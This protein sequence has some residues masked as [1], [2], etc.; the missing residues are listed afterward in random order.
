MPE[1]PDLQA[2]SRNLSKKLVGLNLARIHARYKKKLKSTEKELQRAFQGATLTS[3]NR[4]GKELHFLFNNGNVLGIHLMLKGRLY[5]FHGKND[6][7]YT[8]LEMVFND[9]TG[10]AVTDYQGQATPTL[11][12]EVPQAP[13]AL[14][15]AAGYR[16]LK[17]RLN[18]SK[19]SIKK[20]LTDQKVIR[21]I[22][23]AYADE[24][25]WHARISPFSVSSSIPDIAIK[26][27]ARSIRTVLTQAEKTIL[28][29]Q[30]G[31]IGGELRDF[32]NIHNSSKTHSPTGGRIIKDERGGRSTYYTEE[33]ELWD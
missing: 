17:A 9:G 16:F 31:I 22:G 24:I 14:S 26:K 6:H 3:I 33:Q 23:N 12:P 19:A 4:E 7:K 21:G 13:D 1:L 11:N 25:L 20:L 8:I 32:L 28:K 15:R 30:P 5:Y 18:K 29:T 27:L 10:L 2:F